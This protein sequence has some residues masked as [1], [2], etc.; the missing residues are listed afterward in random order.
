[1]IKRQKGK[2]L[3]SYL[4]EPLF[5]NPSCVLWVKFTA[6]P[7]F[8]YKENVREQN[9]GEEKC[10][11]LFLDSDHAELQNIRNGRRGLEL[12]RLELISSGGR[13]EIF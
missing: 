11:M 2:G 5:L 1:M 3:R 13:C 6:F 7:I 9:K 12:I 8:K 10:F 4:T